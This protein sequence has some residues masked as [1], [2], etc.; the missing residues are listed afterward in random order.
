LRLPEVFWLYTNIF[1]EHAAF[2]FRVQAGDS[3][4]PKKTV[5]NKMATNCSNP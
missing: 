5:Y 4:F 3:M 1:E 2:I